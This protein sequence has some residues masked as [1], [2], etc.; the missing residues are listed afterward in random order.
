MHDL[1]YDVTKSKEINPFPRWESPEGE[2][3]VVKYIADERGYR[4]LESNA[5]PTNADGLR[6]NGEQGDLDGDSNE[7]EN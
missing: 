7:D 4:V 3:F 5:V 1:P 6:A 2:E